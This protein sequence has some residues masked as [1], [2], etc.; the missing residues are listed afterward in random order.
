MQPV[1]GGRAGCL[2]LL[3]AKQ[4]AAQ[5]LGNNAGTRPRA[6]GRKLLEL[7]LRR[8]R[9]SGARTKRGANK[10]CQPS[11]QPAGKASI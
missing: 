3:R 8:R 6:K 4:Q 2:L 11:F 7:D 10:P 5:R 1:R 9:D